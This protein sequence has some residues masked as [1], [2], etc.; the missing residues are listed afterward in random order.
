MPHGA[1][2][3]SRQPHDR[4]RYPTGLA[5]GTAQLGPFV[6]LVGGSRDGK[7]FTPTAPSARKRPLQ[8]QVCWENRTILPIARISY[9]LRGIHGTISCFALTAGL[10]TVT[11]Y[12]RS[13]VTARS[14]QRA[15]E[16]NRGE[17]RGGG[18]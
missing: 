1:W 16:P 7:L 9:H 8:E 15:G 11:L 3:I 6:R 17:A 10:L 14:E 4:P 13:V 12:V 2:D 5:E 18:P